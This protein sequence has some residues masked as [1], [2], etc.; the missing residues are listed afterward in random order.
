MQRTVIAVLLSI[1]G[2]L[3][4]GAATGSTQSPRPHDIVAHEWGTFTSVAGE[5]GRA[6]EWQPFGGP[7]DLPCFVNQYRNKLGISGTVRM[8]TPVIYFYSSRPA[9]VDVSVQFRQGLVTEWFPAAR[10]GQEDPAEY[11]RRGRA[12]TIAWRGVQVEPAG[13][14]L[15]PHDETGSHYYTARETDAAPLRAGRESEKFLFYRGVGSFDLPLAATVSSEGEVTIWNTGPDAI[16]IVVLFS[17][18][19]GSARFHVLR[20]VGASPVTI[21]AAVGPAEAGPHNASG[22]PFAAVS[23]ELERALVSEGLYPKEASAM[24][25]TWGDSWFEEGTRLFYVVPAAAIDQVLPLQIDPTPVETIRTFVGRLELITPDIQREVRT[26]LE[27]GNRATVAK[28]S[29]FLQ[30]IGDRIMAALPADADPRPMRQA[31]APLK[32]AIPAIAPTACR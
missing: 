17:N 2:A 24:V 6:V 12:S 13:P 19:G 15:F 16:P 5:D 9:T 14:A 25:R 26:A 11:R 1:V 21:P 3:A 10:T 23:G 28:Y 18:R 22:L 8:E 32:P 31:L 29:R 27:A 30:P 20:Q 4:A 7:D